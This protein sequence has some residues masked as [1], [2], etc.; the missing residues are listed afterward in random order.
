MDNLL[1]LANWKTVALFLIIVFVVRP[2]GVFLSSYNSSLNTN[3]KLFISWVGP[4]GIVAAGIASLFGSKLMAEDVIGAEY[5]TPLV[6][7][8]VLGTVL[9]NA[10]TA[11]LFARIVGVFLNKSEGILIIG[12]SK[13]SRLL[14]EYLSKN[15]RHVV[16]V[17]N[18]ENNINIAKELGLAAINTN[19][20]SDSIF[21]DV[22]LNDIGY[23]MALTANPDINS[24]A[25][26]K[27]GKQFGENGSFK[28]VAKPDLEKSKSNNGLFSPTDDYNSLADVAE[29]YPYLN[30]VSVKGDSEYSEVITK[31]NSDKDRIPIF[32]KDN[33]G[34]LH[35][36][37]SYKNMK[38]GIA[39][40]SKLV[41]LGKPKN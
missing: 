6:F 17:D 33:K 30:E 24:Y 15:D 28:L 39:K 32:L 8:V 27:L 14:G 20:Y 16:L 3:E 9:L 41:Y 34:E 38:N 40:N 23:L 10:T 21:D 5:I 4:R 22:E 19:I 2:I 37:S 12:A 11:R 26:N 29:N 36:I 31:I 25:V 35:I 13:V 18:N 1:L 7:M